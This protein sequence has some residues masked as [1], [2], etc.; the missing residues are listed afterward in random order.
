LRILS[1]AQ[2]KSGVIAEFETLP[3]KLAEAS[4]HT[5]LIGKY[6]LGFADKPQNGFK[7]WGTMAKGMMPSLL[8]FM[9]RRHR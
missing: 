1:I 7:H 9:E 8:E 6:H 4:Y 3:E 2:Q 5:A